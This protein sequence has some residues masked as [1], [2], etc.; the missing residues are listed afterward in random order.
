MIGKSL[1]ARYTLSPLV[2]DVAVA[3]LKNSLSSHGKLLVEV[4][5]SDPRMLACLILHADEAAVRFCRTL[6]FRMRPGGSGVF[7]LSGEDA[8]RIVPGLSKAEQ[9][10]VQTPC[11]ER[12]TKVLLISDGRALLSI[13]I[14]EG[15][16]RVRIEAFDERA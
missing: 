12:Q 6:G 5:A 11:T 15:G 3:T 16:G 10:F 7:G 13:D 14:E 1:S 4:R 2:P 9:R 8:A